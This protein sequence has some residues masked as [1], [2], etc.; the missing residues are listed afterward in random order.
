MHLIWAVVVL[1]LLLCISYRVCVR[2]AY[3]SLESISFTISFTILN[4][5]QCRR[6]ITFFFFLSFLI[7]SLPSLFL[8]FNHLLYINPYFF[9]SLLLLIIYSFIIVTKHSHAVYSLFNSM[10][11]ESI[12]HRVHGAQCTIYRQPY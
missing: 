9:L 12:C 2:V 3:V 10:Q 11:F 1:L 4:W 8:S 7:H 6:F 5:F